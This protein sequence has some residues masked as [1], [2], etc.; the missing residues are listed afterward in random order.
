M[1][2][3]SKNA[4]ETNA[5]QRALGDQQAA[6]Q[7]KVLAD[8]TTLANRVLD[9]IAADAGNDSPNLPAPSTLPSVASVLGPNEQDIIAASSVT[10]VAREASDFAGTLAA[11]QGDILRTLGSGANGSALPLGVQYTSVPVYETVAAPAASSGG[12]SGV[13][14]AIV[15][16][17][18]GG[19][20]YYLMKHR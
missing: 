1:S 14:V 10:S 11:S 8:K 5:N 4:S 17:A 19:G 9:V 20:A 18:V 12:G 13:V 3:S 7:A 6:T 2:S 16:V 15:V